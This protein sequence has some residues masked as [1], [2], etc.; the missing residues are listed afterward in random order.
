M[1]SLLR[2]LHLSPQL[3]FWCPPLSKH[4]QN[5]LTNRYKKHF[6]SV[7]LF[8]WFSP[9]GFLAPPNQ[10][11]Q[12]VICQETSSSVPDYRCL[13]AERV[14]YVSSSHFS[15]LR[16]TPRSLNDQ[17]ICSEELSFCIFH[18]LIQPHFLWF[19]SIF[20]PLDLATVLIESRHVVLVTITLPCQ[21]PGCPPFPAFH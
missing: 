20:Y 17:V 12:I 18:N 13:E 2:F 6:K 1:S 14:A 15:E 8:V 9:G 16:V 10:W 19:S 5:C 3:G 4:V 21:C 11:M 7:D